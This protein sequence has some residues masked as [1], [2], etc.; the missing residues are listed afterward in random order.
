VPRPGK[1]SNWLLHQQG[2]MAL[3]LHNGAQD[4]YFPFICGSNEKKIEPI[5]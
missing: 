2:A 1:I 4:F 3:C 5:K